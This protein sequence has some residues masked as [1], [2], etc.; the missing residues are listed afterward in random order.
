M[1]SWYRLGRPL[2]LLLHLKPVHT[3]YDLVTSVCWQVHTHTLQGFDHYNQKSLAIPCIG[4]YYPT[5]HGSCR[6]VLKS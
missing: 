1:S 3:G 2:Q 5:T 6:F 4:C